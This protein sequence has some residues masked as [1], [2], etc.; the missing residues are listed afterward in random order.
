[1]AVDAPPEVTQDL[2]RLAAALDGSV[3]AKTAAN[4]LIA[5]WNVRA[6]GDLTNKWAAGPRDS[7]KRDWHAVACI[8]EV[9][10]RFDVIALQE[11]RRNTTALRFLLELLGP[12][13]RVIASDVTEGSAGNGERLAFLYNTERVQ[14]SGLVGEIV[15][16]PLE[17]DPQ[18][19]F[20]R[21]PY[22]AGFSRT[23]TEFTLASVHVLWG[24]NATERLPEVTAFAHWTRA[25]ADRPHDTTSWFWTTSTSTASAT[26]GDLPA[27]RRGPPHRSE[28]F[29]PGGRGPRLGY[30]LE[31]RG[32]TKKSPFW[33]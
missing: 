29:R 4:L 20:A 16:P 3:P 15:L 32:S 9:V 14:P 17:T 31:E 6:F 24:K 33:T 23:G 11:V 19:Q 25:W 22:V 5:T 1:M 28:A 12:V 13:W 10:S 18:R 21:T 30:L 2:T 7:P 8:A 27:R 26:P